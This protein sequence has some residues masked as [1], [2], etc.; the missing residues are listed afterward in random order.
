MITFWSFQ[1]KRIIISIYFVVFE[2]FNVNDVNTNL[3][4]I[5]QRLLDNIVA[6]FENN[7]VEPE[8]QV[9]LQMLFQCLEMLYN[10]ITLTQ[11]EATAVHDWLTDYCKS[12]SIERL[13]LNALVHKLLFA[14]RIRTER[15]PIFEEISKQIEA[16]LQQI[17]EVCIFVQFFYLHVVA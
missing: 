16:Q 14:Q 9:I 10:N 3:I 13:E 1:T 7:D 15:G 8:H 5:L 17:Q 2:N 11:D 6:S 4:I 12:H